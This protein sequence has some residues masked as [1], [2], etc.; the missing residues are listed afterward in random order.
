MAF[1]HSRKDTYKTARH[2]LEK[3]QQEGTCGEFDPSEHPKYGHWE[4]TASKSRNKEIRELF[5]GGFSCHNAG[6]L[7]QTAK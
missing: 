1:V 3:A 7:N 2:L 4:K 6:T 5:A